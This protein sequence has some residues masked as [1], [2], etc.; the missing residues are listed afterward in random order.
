MSDYQLEPFDPRTASDAAFEEYWRLVEAVRAERTPDDPAVP[1][2]VLVGRYRGAPS[3]H[4]YLAQVARAPGT[5]GL[6]GAALLGLDTSGD[7][8]HLGQLELHVLAAHRRNGLGRRLLG[9]A[10]AAAREHER[11]LLIGFTSDRIPAGAAFAQAAGASPGLE[12][13][14]SQLVLAE[15]DREQLR[16]WRERAAE[17]ASGFEL[18][19]WDNCYPEEEL[20]AFAELC[21]A[22]N[23]APRD[24]LDVENQTHTPEKV[25]Q[26]LAMVNASGTRV[27]TLVARERAT[28]ALA[29]CTELLLVGGREA[30]VQQGAT[31]VDPPYR[32]RGLGRWLKADMLERA[33]RDLPEARF[34]RTDNAESNA[35]M[36]AI[37]VALGFRPF[38]AVTVW[39]LEVARALEFAG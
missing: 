23:S 22:M 18:V 34:V 30:I 35:P 10:A 7:N 29:G 17:R 12:E 9:W 15:V 6:V 20:A 25:R 16:A 13:R 1:L 5:D 37:N 38:M 4:L 31:M 3:H 21:S 33:L 36:L 11:R 2:G 26:W 19:F 14:H 28:G 24:D 8:A 32:N 39:Q 27:W